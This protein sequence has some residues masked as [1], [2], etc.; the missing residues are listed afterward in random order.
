MNMWSVAGDERDK[1]MTRNWVNDMY[2]RECVTVGDYE[3]VQVSGGM[4]QIR[5]TEGSGVHRR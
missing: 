2:E 4:K 3:E 1:H 5:E